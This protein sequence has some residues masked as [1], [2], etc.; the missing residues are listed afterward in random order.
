MP[1]PGA[2]PMWLCAALCLALAPAEARGQ[3]MV[4]PADD[5]EE[6]PPASQRVDPT[7]LD[8]AMEYLAEAFKDTG[9]IGAI[10]PASAVGRR[11]IDVIGPG[12]RNNR[13]R[14]RPG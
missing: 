5:W 13:P 2:R 10:A 12:D 3:A 6:A 14:P 11:V 8:A 1:R 4:F 7:K 9:G